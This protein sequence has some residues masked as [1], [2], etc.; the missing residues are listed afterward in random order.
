MEYAESMGGF[1]WKRFLITLGMGVMVWIGSN[2]IQLFDKESWPGGF[3]L[4]GGSCTVTGYPIALCLSHFEKMK[5]LLIYSVN[6][7]FWFLV[8]HLFW[9]WFHK[10]RG[11]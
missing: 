7:I 9:N 2:F 5:I 6:I 3:S 4:L 10:K 1:R 8:I 11:S